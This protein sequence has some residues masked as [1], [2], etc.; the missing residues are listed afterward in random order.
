M[1]KNQLSWGMVTF[2]HLA[3]RRS[4]SLFCISLL[5]HPSV[6]L[7]VFLSVGLFFRT[8]SFH[9]SLSLY[10]FLFFSLVFP[11]FLVFHF[12]SFCN[13]LSDATFSATPGLT[14][15]FSVIYLYFF[16]WIPFF[17]SFVLAFP[18]YLFLIIFFSFLSI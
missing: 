7:S 14:L 18:F 17:L 1:I 16:S 12:H 13:S 10:S 3:P 9:L 4:Q 11:F 6:I 15:D 8:P 2:S 5:E